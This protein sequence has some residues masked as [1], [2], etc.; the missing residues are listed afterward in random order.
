MPKQT[1]VLF[2]WDVDKRLRRHLK[3]RLK[4]KSGIHSARWDE[5]LENVERAD[6]GNRG[7]INL[8]DLEKEY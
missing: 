4:H 7:F 8:V 2:I 1:T 5:V 3:E 6:D